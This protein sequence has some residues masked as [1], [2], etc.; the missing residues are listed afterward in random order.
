MKDK[1]ISRKEMKDEIHKLGGFEKS[2]FLGRESEHLSSA[3]MK[4]CHGNARQASP[5]QIIQVK[6]ESTRFRF[7]SD[8]LI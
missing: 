6:S 5:I 2:Q 4:I 7:N 3:R 1:K 8:Y